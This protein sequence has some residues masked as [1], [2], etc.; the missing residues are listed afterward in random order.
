MEN[1]VIE[2]YTD[3]SDCMVRLENL[4][5][6]AR[7]YHNIKNLTLHDYC[8]YAIIDYT[9]NKDGTKYACYN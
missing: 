5:Q 6:Y 7:R 1:K 3:I 4:A 2:R 8:T 9:Y